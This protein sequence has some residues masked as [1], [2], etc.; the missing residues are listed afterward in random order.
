MAAGATPKYAK[1]SFRQRRTDFCMAIRILTQRL[2]RK[3]PRFR[4]DPFDQLRR[5]LR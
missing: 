5:R 4:D 3:S 1:R 2:I